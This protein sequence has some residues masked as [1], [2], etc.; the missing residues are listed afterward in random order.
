M[1]I[2]DECLVLDELGLVSRQQMVLATTRRGSDDE[3]SCA[4]RLAHAVSKHVRN[5]AHALDLPVLILV[6]SKL[7]ILG[8][9]TLLEAL[10]VIPE[11]RLGMLL[12]LDIRA[13]LPIRDFVVCD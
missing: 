9:V 5:F 8:A 2:A 10:S 7:A 12:A 11:E 6:Q 3:A 13:M 1:L 4:T